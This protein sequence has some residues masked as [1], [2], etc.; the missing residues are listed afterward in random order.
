[1]YTQDFPHATS[2]HGDRT[3][4]VDLDQDTNQVLPSPS[5]PPT[6]QDWGVYRAIF[7]RLYCT[8]NRSLREVITIMADQH[9]FK[10]T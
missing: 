5:N 4:N 7:T 1:M 8:E 9:N 6:R 10:A 3:M 2:Y